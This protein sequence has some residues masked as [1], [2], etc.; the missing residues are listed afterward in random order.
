VCIELY[1]TDSAFPRP[2]EKY[3]LILDLDTFSS[4]NQ[5]ASLKPCALLNGGD[6]S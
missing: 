3:L 4:M 2:L 1:P 6:G 5:D